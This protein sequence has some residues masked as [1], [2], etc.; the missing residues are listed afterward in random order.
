[1]I[2]YGQELYHYGIPGQKWYRRRFQNED[3]SLTEAGRIRVQ[4]LRNKIAK[5]E[6]VANKAR[7]KYDSYVNRHASKDARLEAK[8]NRLSR[9]ANSPFVSDE[10]ARKLQYKSLKNQTKAAKSIAKANKYRAR[11]NRAYSKLNRYNRRLSRFD[12][13]YSSIGAVRQYEYVPRY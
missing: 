11:V 8:A 4:R 5:Q 9:R 10:R 12:P 1:M 2:Y 6:A 3:G 13:T 7:A